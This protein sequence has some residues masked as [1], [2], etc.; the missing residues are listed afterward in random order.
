VWI[1][2]SLMAL[3]LAVLSFAP[4]RAEGFP[5]MV[6]PE[7]FAK[8]RLVGAWFEVAATPWFLEKDC[9]GTTVSVASREDSRLVFKLAC[10]KG[11]IDGKV[12]PIEGLLAEVEPGSYVLRLVRLPEVGGVPLIVLWQAEDDSMAVIAAPN[13]TVG[14]VWSK[15]AHPD[16][17]ALEAAKAVLAKYGY[18]PRYIADIEQ[19]K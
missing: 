13:G 4:L 19:G 8:A 6:P 5:P 2:R 18:N 17:A 9:H 7:G 1:D 16:P 12:L 11:S 15:T 14:W 10:R 3:A